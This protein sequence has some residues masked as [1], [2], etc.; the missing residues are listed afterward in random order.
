MMRL[1]DQI[2]AGA[3]EFEKRLKLN[4]TNEKRELEIKKFNAFSEVVY[5][6]EMYLFFCTHCDDKERDKYKLWSTRGKFLS[7]YQGQNEGR[8]KGAIRVARFRYE[9][10]MKN[11]IGENTI[12]SILQSNSIKDLKRVMEQFRISS[13]ISKA[14]IEFLIDLYGECTTDDKQLTG[15]Q[16]FLVYMLNKDNISPDYGKKDKRKVAILEGI[17][18]HEDANHIFTKESFIQFFNGNLVFDDVLIAIQ[19]D[20]TSYKI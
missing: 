10:K 18:T 4:L 13:N 2:I 11:L 7:D 8:S 9:N 15:E 3:T 12:D 17:L 16:K 1:L 20:I 5:F 19:S 6:I 14:K